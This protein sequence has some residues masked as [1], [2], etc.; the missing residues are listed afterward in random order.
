MRASNSGEARSALLSPAPAGGRGAGRGQTMPGGQP[1]WPEWNTT[2]GGYFKDHWNDPQ[3]ITVK[4]DD[5]TSPLTTMFNAQPFLYLQPG[6]V[7]ARER[8]RPD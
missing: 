2:I 1:L 6:I 8:A 7:L 5:A 3:I 4:I